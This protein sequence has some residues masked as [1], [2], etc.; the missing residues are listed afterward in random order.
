MISLIARLQHPVL[1]GLIT[2]SVICTVSLHAQASPCIDTN[3]NGSL[4]QRTMA[5]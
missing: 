4:S 2:L 3:S 5:V 1:A